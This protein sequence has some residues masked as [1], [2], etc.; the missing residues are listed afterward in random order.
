[1]RSMLIEFEK[2]RRFFLKFN[3]AIEKKVS[4]TLLHT[5]LNIIMLQRKFAVN[6]WF[7]VAITAA[8]SI[9]ALCLPTTGP[10]LA[11][12]DSWPL[13][14]HRIQSLYLILYRLFTPLSLWF[15]WCLREH[16]ILY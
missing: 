15:Y 1:M 2:K 9:G 4:L 11:S 5:F 16:Q 7:S 10:V 13:H 12:W 3:Q 8:W 14:K 6:V